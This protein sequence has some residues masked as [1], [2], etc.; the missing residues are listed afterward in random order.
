MVP[1]IVYQCGPTIAW[2]RVSNLG[3][4]AYRHPRQIQHAQHAKHGLSHNSNKTMVS[5]IAA[6][7][8]FISM[9]N[10]FHIVHDGCRGSER[11]LLQLRRRSKCETHK[12]NYRQRKKKCLHQHCL[13]ML[14][15]AISCVSVST[16]PGAAKVPQ[17]LRPVPWGPAALLPSASSACFIHLVSTEGLSQEG[18]MWLTL[19][20]HMCRWPTV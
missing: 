6:W 8:L 1:I 5:D 11:W 3:Y 9:H 10:G 4:F 15:L 14:M 18:R 19:E 2:L 17:L 12:M 20:T 7:F 13:E 16:Y